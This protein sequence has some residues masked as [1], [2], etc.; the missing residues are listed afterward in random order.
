MILNCFSSSK[1]SELKD[2]A[3][4]R[5]ISSVRARLNVAQIVH[6]VKASAAI[7]F[8]FLCLVIVA[9][10]LAAFGLV[11][12]STLFLAASMLISPLM[13][14]I[15]AATFGTVI[16]DR[17]LQVMGV[18]NEMIGIFLATSVGFIF[19]II[20][21]S[22]DDRYGV[23][24]G[25]TNEILSRCELHSLLV[26]VLIALPSG[27]A[28]AIAILGENT[29]SLVGTAISASLLPPAVNAGLLW[30]LSCVYILFEKDSTRYNSVIKTNYYSNHQ[31]I[32]L[33]IFG[34]IS[35]CVTLTN[36][37]CIYFMGVLFLKIKEVSPVASRGQRTFWKHDIKIARDYNKTL[38][39]ND[40]YTTALAD[41]LAHFK[42]HEKEKIHGI[43]AELLRH[44]THNQNTWSPTIQPFHNIF[45][46]KPHMRDLEAIYLGLAGPTT[47]SNNSCIERFISASRGGQ[48]TSLKKTPPKYKSIPDDEM[49]TPI[50]QSSDPIKTPQSSGSHKNRMP[51]SSFPFVS[52]FM[53]HGTSTENTSAGSKKRFTVLPVEDPL[54]PKYV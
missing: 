54:K 39:P 37:I 16:K 9:S 44:G 18:I 21:C 42:L 35:M 1:S 14:P 6:E 27:A 40:S 3:W 5:L 53:K 28:V 45:H 2:G 10:I 30:A 23:G 52:R 38:H 43:G 25:L 34:C 8:D 11:E 13:G 48:G 7:T 26:G 33:A 31:S 46:E 20:V 22:L 36:I 4:N 47:N 51:S 32:E 19:G 49:L 15:L 41:E 29:G 50:R 17:P 24:E 12:D